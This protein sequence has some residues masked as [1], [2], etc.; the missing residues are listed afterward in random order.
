MTL[1]SK[2]GQNEELHTVRIYKISVRF[3]C[4]GPE[5]CPLLSHVTK[6]S[7]KGTDD[8]EIKGGG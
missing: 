8:E 6:Y 1:Y 4:V 3:G 5:L 7:D 2:N